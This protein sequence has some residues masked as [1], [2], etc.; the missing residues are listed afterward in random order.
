[1]T[2]PTLLSPRT[3]GPLRAD[4]PHHLTDGEVRY[5]V[6]EGIA[7]LRPKEPL[8]ACVSAALDRGHPRAAARL[9]LGDQD[10][11][12]PTA[13]PEEAALDRLLDGADAGLTL[14]EAMG[15]LHFG[16]VGD[17]FAHRWS[18]PTFQSGA[19]LLAR[20]LQPGRPVVEV[21]CGVGHFLRLLEGNGYDTVGVDVV[22]A[23]LWLA[24]RFLG[25]EGA[26]V[27]GDI[28]AGP[29]VSL[30]GATGDTPGPAT[31]FCHDAFYFFEDKDAAL[32]HLRTIARGGAVAVGHVHTAG[33]AHEAGFAERL[34]DYRARLPAGTVAWDD[35][36]LA[37]A[38]VRA[39][40]AP[41][42]ATSQSAA[43]AWLE[44]GTAGAG[45]APRRQHR[46]APY[47]QADALR[48]NPL[49]TAAGMT[50]PS[51]GWRREY[52]ADAGALGAHAL[53][54]LGDE[55]AVRRLVG[56]GTAAIEA[57]PETERALRWRQRVLLDLPTRW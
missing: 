4:G 50:Y 47:Y 5:P 32:A 40:G 39:E 18:S 26:L 57:L 7:F 11:F 56:G 38:W 21:A 46:R 44:P 33:D 3:G 28:E 29:V 49:L 53:G 2:P 55:T 41:A 15:L 16:P 27:C 19:G 6:V 54:P 43:I 37:R 25:V 22:F 34:P 12:S 48:A 13:P 17:Y 20:A 35:G 9:L 45:E 8:R 30:G 14:R 23:K 52:A 1:M 36:S 10:R 31:V 42:E 51:E 24:R